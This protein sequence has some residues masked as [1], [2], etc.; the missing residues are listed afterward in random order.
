[1]RTWTTYWDNYKLEMI[2]QGKWKYS[3]GCSI[4]PDKYLFLNL[5]T[6][7][8]WEYNKPRDV[9]GHSYSRKFV[10]MTGMEINSNRCWDVSQ[11]TAADWVLIVR[12]P[13]YVLDDADRAESGV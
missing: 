8:V 3:S 6:K 1:M 2:Q 13:K 9:N 5:E 10:I 4:D 7:A 11:I 12:K